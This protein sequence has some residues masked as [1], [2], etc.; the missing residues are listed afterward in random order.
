MDAGGGKSVTTTE[1]EPAI[2]PPPYEASKREESH[3]V[4]QIK[5]ALDFS[6]NN[7]NETLASALAGSFSSPG[8]LEHGDI[9][10]VRFFFN[11]LKKPEQ[12]QRDGRSAGSGWNLGKC[13]AAT[14]APVRD[15][16]SWL[17]DE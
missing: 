14:D 10:T 13:E 15:V 6:I 1:A 7:T 16:E 2:S 8:G 12:K 5:K 11:T 4:S 3:K 17:C 9:H